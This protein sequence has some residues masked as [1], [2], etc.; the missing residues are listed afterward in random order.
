MHF[1]ADRDGK[2]DDNWMGLGSWQLGRGKRGA[3]FACN[4]D[5]DD[6][7]RTPDNRDG[8]VNGGNDSSELAPIVIRKHGSGTAPPSWT[9]VLEVAPGT[10]RRV[11]TLSTRPGGVEVIG[12]AKGARFVLPDLAFTEKELGVEALFFAGEDGGWSGMVEI[13]FEVEDPDGT[14]SRQSGVM[15]VAPWMMPSHLEPAEKVFVVDAGRFNRRFRADLTR[16]I[17]AA[18]CSVQQHSEPED[19]WMQDCMEIGY[20]FVPRRHMPVVMRANRDRQL[21]TFPKTLLKPDVGYEE[22]ARITPILSTFDSNGNLE[23]TPPVTSRDGTS[24]PW[25]RIYLGPGRGTERFD[26]EVL[27]FL[28]AQEMQPPIMIDTSWLTVGHVDEIMSFV[29]AP[30]GKGFRLLLASPARAFELLVNASTAG[31][32][33]ERM[34]IGRNFEGRDAE[35]TIDGFLNSGLPELDLSAADLQKFN[36]KVITRLT[37]IANQLAHDISLDP[38]DLI[39]VPIIFMPN[40]PIAEW[41]DA[42]TSGMVNM[43][44]VN[45]HCI[46]PKPFGP[47]VGG[48][49]LFEEDL[50]ENLERLGLTVAFIDEWFEYHVNL[51]EVHCA[52]NTLRRPDPASWRWWQWAR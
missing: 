33:R 30:D 25:G 15:R 41:A 6:G 35:T 32:G 14:V 28:S 5:D 12:P 50:R 17:R 29:P 51:G 42:V 36:G 27:K 18:G 9:A 3:I 38:T 7:R 47:V 40:S 4:N 20:T 34:L 10:A 8:R 37:A 26:P 22:P 16:L 2:V 49:D 52:T 43:L 45:K 39:E 48:K 21:L 46:V 31:F 44:V 1:D 24:Y 23:V 13:V 11:R 19:I